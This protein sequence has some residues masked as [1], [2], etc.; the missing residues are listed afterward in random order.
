MKHFNIFDINQS[1]KYLHRV[2]KVNV[3]I[4]SF[5]LYLTSKSVSRSGTCIR[6]NYMLYIIEITIE[7]GFD[8]IDFSF[9]LDKPVGHRVEVKGVTTTKYKNWYKKAA[10]KIGVIVEFKGGVI[11]KVGQQ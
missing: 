7:E 9:W 10:Q 8:M 2:Q 6:Y 1:H 5:D 4:Y 11:E 3:S